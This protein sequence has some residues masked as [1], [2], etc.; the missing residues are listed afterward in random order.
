M[1]RLDYFLLGCTA[2]LGVVPLFLFWIFLF[3]PLFLSLWARLFS[4]TH[5]LED[6]LQ[7]LRRSNIKLYSARKL[8][9]SLTYVNANFLK[10]AIYLFFVLFSGTKA[11]AST[12]DYWIGLGEHKEIALANGIKTFTVGNPEV[13]SYKVGY[14]NK[15]LLIKGKKTGSTEILIWDKKGLKSSFT[16]FVLGRV[17]QREMEEVAHQ[18]QGENLKIVPVGESL[19]IEGTIQKVDIF[20]LLQKIQQKEKNHIWIRAKVNLDVK[21]WII[22]DIYKALMDLNV[23]YIKCWWEQSD[24]IC[25]VPENVKN[26]EIS[27]HFEETYGVR[28]LK[29][30]FNSPRKN[31]RLKFKI[32][33]I[34]NI[35]GE[36]IKLGLDQIT[37]QLGDLFNIGLKAMLYKNPFSINQKDYSFSTLASPEVTL[38]VN[39]SSTVEIGQ[40]IP[41]ETN[42][43]NNGKSINWKFAGLKI[44]V[45]LVEISDYFKLEYESELSNGEVNSSIR[46][47]KGKSTVALEINSPLELFRIELKTFSKNTDQMPFISKI[48]IIGEIFKSKSEKETHKRISGVIVLEEVETKK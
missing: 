7:L 31:F 15:G 45:K 2:N 42:S 36:E 19:W 3:C 37:G 29:N 48:P 13:L 47:N 1:N 17:K 20:V 28:F 12:T 24:I 46:G 30:Q 23:E 33:Q 32:I 38:G 43:P 10:V 40:E 6:I 22:G 41:F 5:V 16:V 26:L 27:K 8:T 9:N 14:G 25:Q 44:L 34:E 35:Q 11:L 39:E 21:K 4:V 18:L